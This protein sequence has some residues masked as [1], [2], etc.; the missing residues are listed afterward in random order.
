MTFI[1]KPV[2]CYRLWPDG[3]WDKVEI[4]LEIPREMA[5]NA[6][7]IESRA[8]ERAWLDLLTE[9]NKPIQ[10]G[11]YMLSLYGVP[12]DDRSSQTSPS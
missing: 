12:N 7:F 3:H 11:L 1:Q 5:D 4:C 2:E 10:I 6:E 9:S 8:V